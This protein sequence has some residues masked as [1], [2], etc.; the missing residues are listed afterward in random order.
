MLMS[1]RLEASDGRV[2]GDDL[3]GGLLGIRPPVVEP[4]VS[5]R[6]EQFVGWHRDRGVGVHRPLLSLAQVCFRPLD[7]SLRRFGR[8]TIFATIPKESG[9]QVSGKFDKRDSE[10]SFDVGRNQSAD[11]TN[12]LNS[13]KIP[14]K[15]QHERDVGRCRF[16]DHPTPK[17]TGECAKGCTVHAEDVG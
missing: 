17:L 9:L 13:R 5:M 6:A 16:F 15:G 11:P 10:T 4:H 7:V 3:F 12:V 2:P 14:D 1:V 8:E